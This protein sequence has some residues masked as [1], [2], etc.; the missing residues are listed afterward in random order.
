VRHSVAKIN[1]KKE[2]NDYLYRRVK[3]NF[4]IG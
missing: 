2:E 3:E 4:G 1:H